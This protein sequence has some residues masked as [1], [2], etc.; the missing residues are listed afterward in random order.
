[1]IFNRLLASKWPA[2]GTPC[3]CPHNW[4]EKNP[5]NVGWPR[6]LDAVNLLVSRSGSCCRNAHDLYN[7]ES[8]LKTTF[9]C[10]GPQSISVLDCSKHYI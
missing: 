9:H 2:T 8:C 3:R 1:M 4:V 10:G 6:G 5:H 7:L